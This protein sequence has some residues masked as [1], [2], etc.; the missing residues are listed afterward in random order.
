M[1]DVTFTSERSKATFDI[2]SFLSEQSHVI[3]PYLLVLNLWTGC[4]T[5]FGIHSKEKTPLL[6]KLETSQHARIKKV[7]LMFQ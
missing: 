7:H 2:N 6:K 4:D 5:T 1:N 3:K